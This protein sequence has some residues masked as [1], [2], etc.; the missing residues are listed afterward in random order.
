ME[1]TNAKAPKA[2]TLLSRSVQI[3]DYVATSGRPVTVSEVVESL[4]LPRPSAH[5][6]CATLQAMGLLVRDVNGKRLTVGP[7]LTR[8]ALATL[9]ADAQAAARR[10]VLRQVVAETQET[11]S[12]TV[13]DGD[14]LLFLDRVESAS[15]LRLQLFAGSRVPLH[16]TSG[17]KLFLALLP[18]ARRR[19]IIEA[20]PLRRYTPSTFTEPRALET[21]LNEIRKERVGRDHQEYVDGLVAVAVP[22]LDRRRRMVAALSV[23]GP[24]SRVDIDR[25]K[26]RYVAVLSRAAATLG[27]MYAE[28][29]A[30]P[31]GA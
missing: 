12:L 9:Q 10:A 3:L 6:I 16:C 7:L 20:R 28:D 14:E 22:I 19:Q 18:P 27:A 1:S 30:M 13:M 24:A 5:R 4:P 31:I 17:G 15:P 26:S 8:I 2:D 11:C 21:E 25:D 23:N 29:G